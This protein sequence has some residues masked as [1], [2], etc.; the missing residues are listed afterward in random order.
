[1]SCCA[2]CPRRRPKMARRHG[3]RRLL[4]DYLRKHVGKVVTK[5]DLRAVVPHVTEWARRIRELRAAGW[6]IVSNNDRA[7]LKPGEYVLLE[8]PSHDSH[9]EFERPISAA[10]RARVLERN[11]YTCCMCGAGAGEPDEL[12]PGRNVRLHIG[13][14]QDRSHG[15]R[16]TLDNLRALCSNCNQGAKNIT[17]EPPSWTWLLAQIKRARIDDQRRAFE[18]LEGKFKE[19]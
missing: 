1:M 16:E 6:K 15:G 10:L 5:E 4:G 3:A 19:S 13:H 18:W 9:Y 7:D 14:I 2:T 12:N 8:L 17:T 11:G